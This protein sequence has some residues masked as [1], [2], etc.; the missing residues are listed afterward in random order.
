MIISNVTNWEREKAVYPQAIN[1]GLEY[2]RATDFSG[3]DLGKYEIEG[4]QMF[5]LLQ[6]VTTKRWEQQRPESHRSFIDIQYL[7]EGEEVI[8]V[9]PLSENAIVSEE[10]FEARDIA[11]YE[12]VDNENSLL[13]QPGDF[14]VFY[15]TDIHRPCCSPSQ[16]KKIRKV[17]IKIHKSL[18][19]LA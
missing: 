2:I 15:P 11:F 10:A 1:R 8:R 14:T 3:L 4:E 13:L 16:D 9:S 18:L 6:E 12:K 17:V 5:A 7:I 19:E